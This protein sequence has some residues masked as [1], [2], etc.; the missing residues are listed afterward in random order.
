M[1]KIRLEFYRKDAIV[2]IISSYINGR[3]MLLNYGY[4]EPY[5]LVKANNKE[6]YKKKSKSEISEYDRRSLQA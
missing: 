4:A 2:K 1:Y 6:V 5:A 3:S